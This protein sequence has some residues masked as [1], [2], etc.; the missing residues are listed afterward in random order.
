[1][2]KCLTI[3]EKELSVAATNMDAEELGNNV[4]VRFLFP[5][6]AIE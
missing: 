5:K 3:L 6:G 4:S 2:N 1:M